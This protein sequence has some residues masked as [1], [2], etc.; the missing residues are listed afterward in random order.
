MKDRVERF[1]GVI[2]DDS[3]LPAPKDPNSKSDSTDKQGDSVGSSSSDREI[4]CQ[5]EAKQRAGGATRLPTFSHPDGY[6]CV[7]CALERGGWD[8]GASG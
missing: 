5:S 4:A 3:E 2:Y 6:N 7:G 1:D 8:C